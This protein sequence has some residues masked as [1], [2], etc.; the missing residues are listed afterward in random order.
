MPDNIH[1][2]TRYVER[3]FTCIVLAALGLITAGCASI[4]HPKGV[5]PRVLTLQTTAYC[6]CRK[7]CN[8]KRNWYFRPVVASGPNKGK[9]KDVGVTAN[10]TD[11]H[12]GTIAADDALFRFGTVMYIPGY[13]YGRVEDR[14]S[15][16][17]GYH[18]D[19]WFGNHD[20]ALAWGARLQK[21]KV[22]LR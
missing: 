4:K 16:I 22:W 15:A 2:H 17:R 12:H 20:D 8:W 11:A 19:L 6:S 1:V 5:Q 13:G 18:I 14:G 9:P 21:V 10:G 3:V 7:C